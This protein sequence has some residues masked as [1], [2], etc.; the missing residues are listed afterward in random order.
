LEVDLGTGQVIFKSSQFGTVVPAAE[1]TPP[2]GNPASPPVT[3][4]NAAPRGNT[5][6]SSAAPSKPLGSLTL[7]L[8]AID[9]Q[10][11]MLDAIVA[12]VLLKISDPNDPKMGAGTVDDA[13]G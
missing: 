13:A 6:L 10:I 8:P 9:A 3:P 7:S 4:S 5:K 11:K 12:S 2:A 1:V